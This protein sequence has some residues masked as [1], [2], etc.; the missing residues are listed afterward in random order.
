MTN[1]LMTT[2]RTTRLINVLLM[3]A[4]LIKR[5]LIA[6]DSS[7]GCDCSSPTQ[8]RTSE[9]QMEVKAKTET[10]LF[11]TDYINRR[12]TKYHIVGLQNLRQ[13]EN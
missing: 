7:A 9:V 2:R 11:G 5:V 8:M 1:E 10:F 13:R 12:L 6:T 4:V 3:V